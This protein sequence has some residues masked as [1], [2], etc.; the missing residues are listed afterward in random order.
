MMET[1]KGAEP[2]GPRVCQLNVLPGHKLDLTFT[3][4]E[5][6][7]FDASPLLEWPAYRALN[8]DALFSAARVEYGSVCWP[9][10]IDCCPDRLYME[11]VPFT[12]EFDL[13]IPTQEA[14]AIIRAGREEYRK[15]GYVPLSNL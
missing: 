6:R 5:R 11:S 12:A 9:G 15:G 8:N 3:N 10:D 1:I 7:I 2:L 4:G 14:Q 13:D